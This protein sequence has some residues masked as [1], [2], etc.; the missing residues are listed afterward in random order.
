M[1]RNTTLSVIAVV[2][3][4]VSLVMII[5]MVTGFFGTQSSSIVN[6]ISSYSKESSSVKE[7]PSQ[8]FFRLFQ[9]IPIPN[10]NGRIDHMDI[11]VIG[12]KLFVAEIENNSLDI[13][14]LKASKRI[15]SIGNGMLNEPQG[16]S[17]FQN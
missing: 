8:S 13:I 4:A 15:H 6:N 5:I 16:V 9:T 14:D 11:D 3:V 1:K 17:L 12:Q 10:V 2:F 7:V